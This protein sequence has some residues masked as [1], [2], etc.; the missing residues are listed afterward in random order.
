MKEAVVL[1]AASTEQRV[2]G[3]HGLVTRYGLGACSIDIWGTL[4]GHVTGGFFYFYQILVPA[5]L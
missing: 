5:K 2:K 1:E 4:R 3:V